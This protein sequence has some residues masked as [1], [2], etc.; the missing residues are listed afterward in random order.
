[1]M[2]PLVGRLPGTYGVAGA[3]LVFDEHVLAKRGRQGV[4]QDPGH[5]IDRAACGCRHDD[6][7]RTV[8]IILREGAGRLHKQHRGG[9][10]N[11]AHLISLGQ[12]Q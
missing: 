10:D 9:E 2:R 1:M 3:G 6:T 8:R 12:S 7:D 4:G 11:P 5:D